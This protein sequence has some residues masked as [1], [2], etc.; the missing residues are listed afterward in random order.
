VVVVARSEDQL[1]ET[2]KEITELGY[3]AISVTADVSDPAAV[4]RV[5]LEVQVTPGI[6]GSARQQCW[7]AGFNRSHLGD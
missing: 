2:V 5:V 7:V 1:A 3:P 6:G 4:G